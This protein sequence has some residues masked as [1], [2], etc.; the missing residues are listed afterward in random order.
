MFHMGEVGGTSVQATGDRIK[1]N[2]LVEE[3]VA[4]K[5]HKVWRD[6]GII[7]SQIEHSKPT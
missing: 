4:C 6:G 2:V 5:F 7:L 3:E 1:S